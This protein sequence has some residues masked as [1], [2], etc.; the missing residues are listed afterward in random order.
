VIGSPYASGILATGP[1]D[2]ARYN[3]PPATP[4][5]LEK[6]R[7]IEAV[8][9]RHGVPLPAAAVQFPL[10]HP[11]AG[12]FVALAQMQVVKSRHQERSLT[13]DTVPTPP[14]APSCGRAFGRPMNSL[15]V[16]VMS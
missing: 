16:S 2:D 8:C 9:R 11:G 12:G 15:G 5:I 4:E 7:R 10:G 1:T 3:Y 14:P 13:G 6:T